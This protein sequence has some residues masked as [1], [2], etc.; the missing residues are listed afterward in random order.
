MVNSPTS[1]TSTSD[2]APCPKLSEKALQIVLRKLHDRIRDPNVDHDSMSLSP[3]VMTSSQLKHGLELAEE[4][5]RIWHQV[6]VEAFSMGQKTTE[7]TDVENFEEK[8]KAAMGKLERLKK[9]EVAVHAKLREGS[10]SYLFVVDE[11]P[12]D[13]F[14][15]AC[16]GGREVTSSTM[17]HCDGVEESFDV[18]MGD[19]DDV[20]EAVETD[21]ATWKD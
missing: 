14:N 11:N 12:R 7:K 18:K 17:G 19:H 15:E 21:V 4:E 1:G 16:S 8:Y 10:Y 3:Q 13:V 20:G 6:F 2:R 5:K 9:E